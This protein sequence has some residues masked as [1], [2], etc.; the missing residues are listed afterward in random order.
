MN[1]SRLLVTL[2]LPCL[3]G[4]WA[5]GEAQAKVREVFTGPDLSGTYSCTGD[6][7]Q[8]GPYTGI[9]TLALVPDQSVGDHGAYTFKLEVPGYGAYPGH[10][11]GQG[12]T[13]AIYF[14]N[15]DPSTKDY[16]TGLATFKKNNKGKWAFRKFYYE[17]EFKGGNHGFERCT[18]N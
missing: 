10:A 9:V 14:A 6:D 3:G 16:G 17:P 11:A 13:L 4:A 12:K 1:A 8:E 2:L 7:T 15:T 18:Q 5:H